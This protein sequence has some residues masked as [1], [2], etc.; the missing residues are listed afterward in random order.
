MYILYK[1]ANKKS[2]FLNGATKERVNNPY[3]GRKGKE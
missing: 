1:I 2:E 3:V